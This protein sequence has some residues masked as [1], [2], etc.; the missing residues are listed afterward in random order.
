MKTNEIDETKKILAEIIEEKEKERQKEEKEMKDERNDK[1]G[2]GIFSSIIFALI[3]EFIFLSGTWNFT[4]G[5]LV[6]AV[7]ILWIDMVIL[8]IYIEPKK[9]SK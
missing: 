2:I 3:L 7:V 9:E 6:G 1:I 5:F 4:T 8:L